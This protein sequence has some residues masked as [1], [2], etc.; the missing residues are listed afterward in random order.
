MFIQGSNS[1]YK[2]SDYLIP[3]PSFWHILPSQA[4]AYPVILLALV[5]QRADNAIQQINCNPGDK[6]E[7][8]VLG[9]PVGG[10]L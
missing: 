4:K 5:V 8:N 10:D 1:N 7:E 9:Y 2:V 6:S 3:Q